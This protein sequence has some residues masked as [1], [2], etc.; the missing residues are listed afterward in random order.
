[1]PAHSDVMFN[2]HLFSL[3]QISNCQSI[4]GVSTFFLFHSF[5]FQA[6]T[7]A[8]ATLYIYRKARDT[9]LY[10]NE[11]QAVTVKGLE[12]AERTLLEGLNY[13]MICFHPSDTLRLL[14]TELTQFF[15]DT[16]TDHVAQH[17][18]AFGEDL[19]NRAEAVCHRA[20]ICSDAPF[21]F[22]PGR[23]AFAATTIA[24]R[25]INEEGAAGIEMEDFI[26]FRFPTSSKGEMKAFVHEICEIV[27][28]LMDCPRMELK[29]TSCRQSW[30]EAEELWQVL[31]KVTNI[32]SF[33]PPTNT[34]TTSEPSRK[35]SRLETD[36]LQTATTTTSWTTKRCPKVTPISTQ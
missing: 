1:M 10:G 17:A 33:R 8:H 3:E 20:L 31:V 12:A 30:N 13:E 19:L 29:V 28:Y 4:T 18:Y 36:H 16:C 5:G 26:R 6:A 21:L 27:D 15:A 24:L 23:I 32:H 9:P 35:R 7:L 2:G 25:S 34:R 22:A 14:S 11:L